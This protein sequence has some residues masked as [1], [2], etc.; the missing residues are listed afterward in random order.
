MELALEDESLLDE[1]ELPADD[2]VLVDEELPR[3]SVL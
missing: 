1:L 3:L 2:G